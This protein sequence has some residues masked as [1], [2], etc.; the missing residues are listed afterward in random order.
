MNLSAACSPLPA[1]DY[2]RINCSLN[3]EFRAKW[4]DAALFDMTTGEQATAPRLSA[5]LLPSEAPRPLRAQPRTPPRAAPHPAR[6]RLFTPPGA[7][8]TA[9]RSVCSH[10]LP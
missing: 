3:L 8:A 7:P 1:D 6:T 10:P 5:C 4:A 2:Q 9:S